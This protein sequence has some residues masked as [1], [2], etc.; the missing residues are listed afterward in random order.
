[1]SNLMC[2]QKVNT[3]SIDMIMIHLLLCCLNCDFFFMLKFD[4]LCE[5][6]VNT[7]SHILRTS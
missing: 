4:G 1:M 3:K 7:K 5:Q 2:D 6:K